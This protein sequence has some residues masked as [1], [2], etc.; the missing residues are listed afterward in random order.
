LAWEVPPATCVYCGT[1]GESFV[2][3]A[4]VAEP[5]DRHVEICLACAGYLKTVETEELLPFPLV[6][7]ADMETMALDMMGFERGASRPALKEF[8]PRR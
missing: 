6:A 4:P 8:A 1:G 5:H 3:A 2:T 7:I